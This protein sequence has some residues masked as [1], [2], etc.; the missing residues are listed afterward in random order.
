MLAAA[1]HLLRCKRGE[2]RRQGRGNWCRRRG[3]QQQRLDRRQLQ[4]RGGSAHHQLSRG[5]LPVHSWPVLVSALPLGR[6]RLQA[7]SGGQRGGGAGA[8]WAAPLCLLWLPALL[9][10][11]CLL[12]CLSRWR[13]LPHWR[14]SLC[15]AWRWEEGQAG[16]S[17]LRKVLLKSQPHQPACHRANGACQRAARCTCTHLHQ[18]A[19][20]PSASSGRGCWRWTGGQRSCCGGWRQDERR[21]GNVTARSFPLRTSSTVSVITSSRMPAARLVVRH[22]APSGALRF[23]TFPGL[24]H[25]AAG[26][27]GGAGV[28]AAAAAGGRQNVL[29]RGREGQQAVVPGLICRVHHNGGRAGVRT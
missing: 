2:R 22:R 29:Q 23:P 15:G 20:P 28:D 16:K 9:C 26:Q 24:P 10:L 1:L 14:Q 19:H 5:W 7:E 12:G 18:G 25:Q 13:V 11:L 3:V 4:R 8:G 21:C 6:R 27:H 17:K